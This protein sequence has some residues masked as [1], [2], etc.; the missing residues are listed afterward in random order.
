MNHVRHNAL[1]AGAALL[2]VVVAGLAGASEAGRDYSTCIKTCNAANQICNAQC[3]TDCK[4]LCAN[5]TSCV[6][7][8]VTNCKA[9]CAAGLT[10]CKLVC[11]SIKNNP[12]PTS[13]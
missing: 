8:C 6:T 11:Q 1:I 5:V 3:N 13:P 9:T 12:S 7:P 2:F 4:D 10:E